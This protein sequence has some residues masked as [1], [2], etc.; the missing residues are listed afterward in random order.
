[1]KNSRDSKGAPSNWQL[2]IRRWHFVPV[3]TAISREQLGDLY[4][5]FETQRN[6]GSGGMSGCWI[7]IIASESTSKHPSSRQAGASGR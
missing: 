5:T 3:Q 2:A 1:M 6:G 7:I 4:K